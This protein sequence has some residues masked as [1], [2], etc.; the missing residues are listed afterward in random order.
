MNASLRMKDLILLELVIKKN[1]AVLG[2]ASDRTCRELVISI[3][4]S[5]VHM[6]S[7]STE[8]R[9]GMRR[10]FLPGGGFSPGA[11]DEVDGTS[12]WNV[13][14]MPFVAM[15]SNLVAMASAHVSE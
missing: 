1:T 12:V 7:L 15:A 9:S 3:S 14:I 4:G 6:G 11:I 2:F 5:S 13:S 10:G 8:V